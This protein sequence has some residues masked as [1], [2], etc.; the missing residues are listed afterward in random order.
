MDASVEL[1]GSEAPRPPTPRLLRRLHVLSQLMRLDRPIG[2]WLLL[3]PT[4]WALWVAGGGHPQ[5]RLLV[6]FTLGTVIMRSAGCVAN[7]LADRNI[8]PHVRRTRTRPLA[9][10]LISPYEAIVLIAL[11]GAAALGLALQLNALS[12]RLAFIGAG[13]TLTYPLMKRFFPMPQLYLGLC[14]GWGVPMAFAAT[15]GTVPRPGWLMLT[16]A[17]LW[18]GI[19]DTEYAMV[20]REDDLRVGVQSTAILFGDLDRAMIG[21][22][23]AMMLLALMLLGRS[24]HFDAWYY[25]GLAGGAALFLWQQWLI[26]DRDRAGCF[27][28]FQNNGYFGTVVFIGILLE[29]ASGN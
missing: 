16:A 13:L 5:R 7:D 1:L 21:A 10:R 19:Y 26:R 29:Y 11:L 23:Q 8:D 22:M 17:V 24:L 25:G 18:A 14:F 12:I 2:I 27:G 20:D 9:A 15:L 6:I 3:W 4:L 28:A